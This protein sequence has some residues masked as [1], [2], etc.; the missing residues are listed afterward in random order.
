MAIGGLLQYSALAVALLASA[1]LWTL[2]PP[3]IEVQTR[4]H[5]ILLMHKHL[6]P[7]IAG[8]RPA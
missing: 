3:L 6:H 1:C 5:V 2:Q 8:M 7:L 4:A